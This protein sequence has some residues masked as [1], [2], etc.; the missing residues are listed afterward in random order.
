MTETTRGG[1]EVI[2]NM[3]GFLFFATLFAFFILWILGIK[4]KWPDLIVF[5]IMCTGIIAACCTFW[6]WMSGIADDHIGTGG[7]GPD[8]WNVGE[9]G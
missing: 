3:R 8:S 4:Y 9:G 5:I 2:S 1:Q 6:Y 7:S